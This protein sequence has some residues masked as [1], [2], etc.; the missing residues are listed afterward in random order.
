M[1]V[2]PQDG[3]EVGCQWQRERD[4]LHPLPDVVATDMSSDLT[5]RATS[6]GMM[7]GRELRKQGYAIVDTNILAHGMW[8]EMG[9]LGDP[10]QHIYGKAG[11]IL[12][13]IWDNL[14]PG[15][16]IANLIKQYEEI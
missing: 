10:P 2:Q 6:I 16:E 14:A 9:N 5:K 3:N 7:V 15:P 11:R 4:V 12:E 8:E 1:E 13:V